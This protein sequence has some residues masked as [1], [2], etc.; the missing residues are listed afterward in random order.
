MRFDKE[1]AMKILWVA[2]ALAVT[3]DAV[4]ASA[5]GAGAKSSMPPW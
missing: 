1:W 2:A 5:T 3:F 4:A